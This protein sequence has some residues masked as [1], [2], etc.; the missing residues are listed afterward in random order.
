MFL[1]ILN[2][3]ECDTF[4]TCTDSENRQVS[5]GYG[6]RQPYSAHIGSYRRVTRGEL[7]LLATH[8]NNYDCRCH[9]GSIYEFVNNFI[10]SRTI[11]KYQ[12][13]KNIVKTILFCYTCM[14]THTI[15]HSIS[16]KRILCCYIA[17][18]KKTIDDRLSAS[19]CSQ[20][21]NCSW[22]LYL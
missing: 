9:L 19:W 21:Q 6:I 3:F 15:T 12:I 16:Q 17:A 5:D 10:S 20:R 14:H 18:I 22:H 2:K 8:S 13:L 7:Q 1:I 11:Y 4:E